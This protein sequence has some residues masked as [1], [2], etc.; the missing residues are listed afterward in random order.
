[1]RPMSDEHRIER[2]VQSRAARF[3]PSRDVVANRIC[4]TTVIIHMKTN[5][6]LE[7]N[8]TGSRLWELLC[9]GHDRTE[10]QRRMLQEFNVPEA[11][12]AS[13][14]ERLL[15]ALRTELLIEPLV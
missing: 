6:I 13:E 11:Q 10:I 3:Q 14:V 4:D 15:A 1:M 5:R 9:E 2:D 12:L 8:R 7:L